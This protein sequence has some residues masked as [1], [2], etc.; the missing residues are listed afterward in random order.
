MALYTEVAHA[1]LL[2]EARTRT[3]HKVEQIEVLRIEPAFLTSLEAK[4]GRNTKLEILRSDGQLY[5]T[6]DGETISGEL[7]SCSLGEE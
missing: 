4:V 5:V 7:V 3:I 1:Q 6:V 2:R